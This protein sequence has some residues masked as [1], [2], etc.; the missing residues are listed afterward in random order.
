MATKSDRI[1]QWI[2]L[3]LMTGALAWCVRNVEDRKDQTDGNQ[4]AYE[5]C[6]AAIREKLELPATFSPSYASRQVTRLSG[7]QGWIV[8]FDFT[9]GNR[10]GAAIAHEAKCVIA[11]DGKVAEAI[12]REKP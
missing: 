8:F 12:A 6:Q 3:A 9:A 2:T 11:K 1:A 10:L 5:S 4:A 7:G